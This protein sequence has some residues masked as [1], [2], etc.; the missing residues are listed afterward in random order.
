MSLWSVKSSALGLNKEQMIRTLFGL[1]CFKKTNVQ[2]LTFFNFF[3]SFVPEGDDNGCNLGAALLG[4]P[5]KQSRTTLAS[6]RKLGFDENSPVLAR[7]QLL[8]SS[9]R[10]P[11]SPRR[12]EETPIGSPA[13]PDA[14]KKAKT[15][16]AVRLFAE[17]ESRPRSR[18]VCE[19]L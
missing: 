16:V 1:C 13:H 12:R 3:L 9:P 17:S 11:L 8:P 14:E 6:P 18:P 2:P 15:P 4:S 19:I 7:R 5:P 10:Q